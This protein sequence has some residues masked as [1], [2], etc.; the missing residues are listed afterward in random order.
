[1]FTLP[2]FSR[3][4]LCRLK[5]GSWVIYYPSV[6]VCSVLMA[7]PGRVAELTKLFEGTR[8]YYSPGTDT[9]SFP[10]SVGGYSANVE[11]GLLRRR[12]RE[13]VESELPPAKRLRMDV[14]Y[15][16]FTA[17]SPAGK[18]YDVNALWKKI[19]KNEREHRAARAL[20]RPLDA[21]QRDFFAIFPHYLPYHVDGYPIRLTY[22]E[23]KLWNRIKPRR[24]R[25]RGY[26]FG[27]FQRKR[28]YT[29]RRRARMYRRR[30]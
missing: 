19:M 29:P 30:K 10:T 6:I 20:K 26:V 5:L 7:E 15:G 24:R 11:P 2:N 22:E 28:R 8:H 1:M 27:K 16:P 4:I 21:Y 13:A 3:L 14:P 18:V 9:V 12:F 23:K 17:P 25:A